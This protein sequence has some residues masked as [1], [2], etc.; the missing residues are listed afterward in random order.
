[1]HIIIIFKAWYDI[2]IMLTAH[3][4]ENITEIILLNQKYFKVLENIYF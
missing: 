3:M 1:M 2:P 4:L